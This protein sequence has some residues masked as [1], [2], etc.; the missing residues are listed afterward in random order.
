M[1]EFDTQRRDKFLELVRQGYTYKVA[2]S[3]A[4]VTYET[5]R[6]HMSN[7][8][9]FRE[10]VEIAAATPVSVAGQQLI[11]AVKNG[12]PWAIKQVVNSRRGSD[13]GWGT[14]PREH[15]V[16]GKIEHEHIHDLPSDEQI[17]ELETRMASRKALQSGQGEIIDAEILEDDSD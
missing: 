6:R 12:E 7:D 16:S 3:T 15:Q 11:T 9:E 8:L 13:E 4:G 1:P 2:A 17:A 10:S 5:V 14:A